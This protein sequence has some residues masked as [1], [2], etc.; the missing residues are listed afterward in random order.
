MHHLKGHASDDATNANWASAMN[1]LIAAFSQ[2]MGGNAAAGS[3]LASLNSVAKP[4]A[5]P[6]PEPSPT[7]SS[8][9]DQGATLEGSRWHL[10]KAVRRAE[11]MVVRP[12]S[13][14]QALSMEDCEEIAVKVE[15][16]INAVLASIVSPLVFVNHRGL[17]ENTRVDL[18]VSDVVTS[19]ELVRCRR[20]RLFLNGHVPLVVLDGC[21][22]VQIYLSA[23]S[24]HVKIVTAQCAEI[25]VLAPASLLNPT[26]EG[27]EEGEE[28][29]EL[30]I[31]AQF[32][33]HVDE[34]GKLITVSH[35]HANV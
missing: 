34:H 21:E 20:I 11:P 17:D 31:P 28:H 33:S 9:L 2:E 8:P 19:V 16:K 22:A 35:E 29:V 4:A 7:S 27:R 10:R 30:A 15:G 14:N 25:N 32:F 12:E 24:R 13:I 5:A 6:R 26:L 18:E 23:P 3:P 1:A